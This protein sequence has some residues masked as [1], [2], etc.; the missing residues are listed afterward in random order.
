MSP[1]LVLLVGTNGNSEARVGENAECKP[2]APWNDR[3]QCCPVGGSGSHGGDRARGG[4]V[5]AW[6]LGAPGGSDGA[7]CAQ[8]AASRPLRS[9][10]DTTVWFVWT[11]SHRGAPPACTGHL[12]EDSGCASPAGL[13]PCRGLRGGLREPGLHSTPSAPTAAGGPRAPSAQRAGDTGVSVTP[14]V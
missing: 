9:H 14:L 12:P 3:P 11:P 5:S 4:L 7:A 1:S 13:L 2:A 10:L 8:R 6:T